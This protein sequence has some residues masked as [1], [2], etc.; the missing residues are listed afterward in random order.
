MR[1][2]VTRAEPDA[3]GQASRLAAL[4]HT[5]HVEPLITITFTENVT[6]PLEGAQG[7]IATSR[8]G[9]RAIAERKEL[10][11]ALA[12]P[13]F[14]VGP[15]SAALGREL[16]FT[17]IHEGPGTADGLVDIIARNSSPGAGSLLHLAGAVLAS[18]LKGAL[19]ARGY[20]IAQ[21]ALYET[22]SEQ[23]PEPGIARSDRRR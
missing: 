21:P 13:L 7:M 14:V 5:S 10:A 22:P 17:T 9:L 2:W 15:A 18:D 4:G 11:G 3:S 16:G 1:I 23:G 20:S 8:N 6:L 12:L 19:E